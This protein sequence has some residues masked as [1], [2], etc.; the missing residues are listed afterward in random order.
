MKKLCTQGIENSGNHFSAFFKFNLLPMALFQKGVV[1]ICIVALLLFASNG[2]YSQTVVFV[3]QSGNNSNS[4]T[5]WTAAKGPTFISTLGGTNVGANYKIYVKGSGTPYVYSNANGIQTNGGFLIKGGFPS[6]ATGTDTSGYNPVAN[7]TTI[8]ITS[9]TLSNGLILDGNAVG[10][11]VGAFRIQGL[12]FNGNSIGNSGASAPRIFYGTLG[13]SSSNIQLD[14]RDDEFYNF[15]NNGYQVVA[16]QDKG[17]YSFDN[18][19][20][21]DNSGANEGAAISIQASSNATLTI[22]NCSFVN[23]TETSPS[24]GGGGAVA[25]VAPTNTITNSYF[26]SNTGASGGAIGTGGGSLISLGNWTLT[27]CT[28]SQNT[29]TTYWGGAVNLNS[30]SA[31]GSVNISSCN[32]YSNSNTSGTYGGGA[33]HLLGWY[34]STVDNCVFYNNSIASTNSAALAA[35]YG[36]GA[37]LYSG[38]QG[39]G[40][41]LTISNSVLDSNAVP[42]AS[43]GGAVEFPTQ[44]GIPAATLILNNVIFVN[45]KLGSSATTNGCDFGMSYPAGS[46]NGAYQVTNSKMQLSTSGS[47][48]TYQSP[49][50]S[51]FTFGSGNIFSNTT[52]AIAPPVLSCPTGINPVAA[53][54]SGTVWNDVDGSVTIN[55]SE[56]GT[57]G[58][59]LFVNLVDVTTGTVVGSVAVAANGTY[60]GLTYPFGGDTYKLVVSTSA[61]SLI[62]GPVPTGYINTGEN[63][64][65]NTA[66][67]SA[68]LGQIELP[69]SFATSTL[70]NQ[71]FGITLAGYIYVHK[72]AIDENSSINFTFNITGGPTSVPTIT[73]NDQPNTSVPIKDLG[74]SQNGRLW[75]VGMNNNTLYYRDLG[76]SLWVTTTITNANAVDGGAGSSVYY[77]TTGGGMAYFDGT[78][79]TQIFTGTTAV[80]VGSAWDNQPFII[81][82]G[83]RIYQYS[84]S[85]SGVV[86]SAAWPQV[87]SSANNINVDG[88]PSTGDAI[89]SKS[90]NNVWRITSAGTA[91]SLGRPSQ[92]TSSANAND[93]AVDAFGGIYSIYKSVSPIAGSGAF[94]FAWTGGTNW[95]AP[96]LSG[97]NATLASNQITAGVGGQ[98]WQATSTTGPFSLGNIF[99]RTNN[100]GTIFW[101]DNDWLLAGS[102]ITNTQ[103]IP[104][105]P[106]TYTLAETVPS[107]W[108]LTAIDIYDP[109][110]NSSGVVATKTSS[111]NVA[112]GEV[113]HVNY[114]NQLLQSL[115]I[116]TGCGTNYVQTYGSGVAANGSPLPGL[117]SYHY[118]STNKVDDGYYTIIK[119]SASWSN[120]TL[121]D[122]TGLANGYFM[123]VNASYTV[124]EFYRQRVTGLSVGSSYTLS[125]WA[126]DLS[127]TAVLRPNVTMGVAAVNTGVTINSINTGN[128]TATNWTLYSFTFIANASTVDIFIANNASGGTGNDIAIDDISFNLTP[129]PALVTTVTHSTCASATGSITVTTS[130]GANIEYS[131]D[132]FAIPANTQSSPV[133]SGITPG[134]YTIYARYVST[135]CTSSKI[136]T[137]KAA[138]CGNV[139]NDLNGLSDNTVNGIGTNAG[140]VNA[141]LYDSTG[142]K[143]VAVI[144]VPASGVIDFGGV[145]VP[146]SKYTV[147]LTT[148]TAIVGQTAVPTVTTPINW[149]NT[150]ENLGSGTGSDGTPNGVLPLG[151]VSANLNNANIGIE[152]L[153]TANAVAAISQQNPG[154][155]AKITVPTLTG[156]DPEDGSYIGTSLT[157]TIKIQSLAIGGTLYYNG[158]AVT[159]GQVIT[160]YNPALLSV[161]PNTATASVSFTYSEVDAAG[162]VSSAA[163]VTMPFTDPVAWG[164]NNAQF[165]QVKGTNSD[166]RLYTINPNTLDS[167]LITT[168]PN[169]AQALAYNPTD[170]LLWLVDSSIYIDRI[171]ANGAKLRMNIPNFNPSYGANPAKGTVTANGYYI[172]DSNNSNLGSTYYTIDI[173]PARGTY[174]QYV[175]PQNGFATI[176]TAPYARKALAAFG[177]VSDWAWN[178][179]D[180]KLYGIS[181]NGANTGFI[182]IFDYTTGIVS[183][184]PQVVRTNGI[185]LGANTYG[186][187]AFDASG[188]LTILTN[189]GNDY[190]AVN[191]TTGQAVLLSNGVATAA[192]TDGAA[193]PTAKLSQIIIGNVYNDVN[194]LTDNLVNGIA[195]NAGGGLYAVLYDNT[196]GKV[197]GLDS[198]YNNGVYSFGATPADNYSVYLTSTLPVIGQNATPPITLPTGWVSTGEGSTA[199]GDLTPNSIIVL[200]PVNSDVVNANFG[201]EQRPGAGAG[202]N[203][204][205]NPGGTNQ[206]T[207]P[208]NTFTNITSSTDTVT[209]TV[210]AI[211]IT[212]FPTGATSIVIG[213]TSFNTLAAIQA[214][215]P[216][217]IPTN[218]SGQPTPTIT[219]DPV[220]IGYGSVTIPFVA[221]DAAGMPSLNTGTAVL[222]LTAPLPPVA[223][224][225]ANAPINN[226]AAQTHIGCFVASDPQGAPIT[227]FTV[228]TL[229]LASQGVLYTCSSNNVPCTGSYTAVT[230]NQ[231]LT[232]AQAAALYFDPAATFVGTSTFTYNA[233]SQNGT[234]NTATEA[235]PVI[236][237]PPT[238]NSFTTEPVAKNSSNNPLPAL[239]GADADGTVVSYTVTPPL[240]AQGTITYCVTPPATG[241]GTPISGA[242]V[243]TSAQAAT[244][245][246]TPASNS[247]GNATFTYT[248]TDN[249]GNVSTPA[250]VT[251]PV[252]AN[253]APPANLPPVTQDVTVA[254]LNSND[255]SSLISPLIGTDPDG[256]IASYTINTIPSAAT[257]IL[258]YCTTGNYPCTGTLTA[259]TASQTLTP[260]QAQTL[261][262]DPAPGN[263]NPAVFTYSATDNSGLGSNVSTYTIP[264]VN[265][266]PTAVTIQATVPFN[267]TNAPIPSLFGTDP[268]GTIA[269]YKVTTVPNPATEG[270]LFYCSNGTVPCTGT[271]SAITSNTVLTP[272]QALTVNFTP[273]TGFVGTATGSY[274]ATDNNGNVSQPAGIILKVDNFPLTGQPPVA[275][276]SSVNIGAN[277]GSTALANTFITATDP[278]G[279]IASYKITSLPPASQG[280]YTYCT[281][282]PSSGCNTLLTV[283]LVLTPTQAAALSFTPIATYSGPAVLGFTATDNSGNV[284]NVANSVVNINSE[285]P[286]ASGYTTPVVKNGG[287]AINTLLQATDPLDNGTI[288]SF[289]ITSIPTTGNGTLTY[290]VAP[291]ATGCN[292]SIAAGTT[293]TPAQAATV[294]YTPGANMSVYEVPFT[295]TATDNSGNGSNVGTIVVPVDKPLPP[296][297]QNIMNAPMNNSLSQTHIGGFVASDPQGDPITSYLVLTLPQV[298][299]G[300]LYT[301]SSNNVP[302]TGSYT[303]VTANQSLTPAQ[304]AALYFDPANTFVGTSTFTYNATSQN[305]TSNTATETIPVINNPPTANSFTT[306]P[307]IVNSSNNLLPPL[308]GADADGTVVSYTVTPPVPAQ[309]SISYCTTPP[310]TGCGSP[311]SGTTVLTP[312]QAAT[313]SFTPATGV[314]G[315]V[316]FTYTAKDNNG[317]VSTAATVIVPITPLGTPPANLPP[318]TQDV[319]IAPLNSNDGSSLI[320]PLIAS[321]PDGTIASY[322]INTIPSASIGVLYYCT[323]GNYPCTGSLTAVTA[324]QTLTGNQYAT[325]QFD[326]ASGNNNP[327]VFTY[328]A[329]DNSSLVSNV[330]TYTIPIQNMPPTAVTIQATVPFNSTNSKI[331]VLQGT[332]PDGTIA[333]YKVTTVPNAATEGTLYYCSN[334]TIPCTG[335]LTAITANTVLMPAQAL[336]VNFTPVTGFTGTANGTYTSTDNN[337]NV[338]LP[339]GIVLRISNYMPVGQPPYATGS[340]VNI[341]ANAGSTPLASNFITATDLDGTIT[342]YKITS[343][344]PTSQGVYTY[345]SNPPA[346]GCGTPLTLGLV[347]TPAQAAVLSFTPVAT[348]SGPA[349]LGFTATDNSGNV[350]NVANSVVNISSEPP[351]AT[352]YTTAVV[353]NGGPAINT[354]L[355]ATD[356][357]DNGTI[358]SYTISSVPTSGNGTLTYCVTPPSSGCGTT[359]TTGMVLSPAQ[360]ATISYTPGTNMTAFEVP[361]TFTATDNSGNLSNVATIVIPRIDNTLCIKSRVYL[362]G[363]LMN[364]SNVTAGGRPLMRDN[365]RNSPITGANYI[366]VTDPYEYATTYVDVTSKYTKMSP[367]DAAHPQFRKVTDSTAVFSVTGQNAIIDWAFVE[368]RSKSNSA[369]VLATR[370]G[371]IQRD[372]D[373]VDVDGVSCLSFPGVTVDSYFVAIRHRS[374]LGVMTKYGQSAT[375]L[376]SLV[377]L[378]ATTTPVYDKG[379]VGANNYT[380]LATN[381]NIQSG[382]RALWQGD[383][384]A[385]KKVKYDN[386]NDDLAVMLDDVLG[387]AGNVNFTTNFDFGYGYFQ[388]DYDMNSK[389]KYDNPND[390]NSMLLDQILG[391]PLNSNFITNFDFMIQQ[392]P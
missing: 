288:A 243:L 37:I 389:V 192:N 154:G 24:Q 225:I 135:T 67:Q 111:L 305:G 66:T 299:E 195:T 270:T 346:T 114:T 351:I 358:V 157:N 300:I 124:N 295:F 220:A 52:V 341:G 177:T 173:N 310:S 223:Q 13:Q 370:A 322:T 338:S 256:T 191:V 113:V 106:G 123:A 36:G 21:H 2:A 54:L 151:I 218:A 373:I 357:L 153:P 293:L 121:T 189:T 280:A 144:A 367:Q 233:T 229:P 213:G 155:N 33:L 167:T 97:G 206:V 105:V 353:K 127:P 387:H 159:L 15:N 180:G 209:N 162:Q 70:A 388:G 16:S 32:F 245:S 86:N 8:S 290:C 359:I 7:P 278:D 324:S 129:I 334:G 331:P 82:N 371:L 376:Q 284:S 363:A 102:S 366:P 101:H 90:D 327:A 161:D 109:T 369:T 169:F 122:H 302:C 201:I 368:L 235:I 251:V 374:H 314:T 252:T 60:S 141:V 96:E 145:A 112:A 236:N 3:S 308:T 58:G 234:S 242:T 382:Y 179:A 317:N 239:T 20:F 176:N 318:I 205:I 98:A 10:N 283:G 319:T 380:G 274:T 355:L 183:L 99:S 139:Y 320:S 69:S 87:G 186:T 116:G 181:G 44:V 150:G 75:A 185:V 30:A 48:L 146:G 291:P 240:A 266:P 238:A 287:P 49:S 18:C 309:G 171:D 117:T 332:D 190:F 35:R 65:T 335:T 133:F 231:V 199:S 294:S 350:S 385:D 241:C 250:T 128:I 74:S 260:A 126:A 88:D 279:T 26:C 392:L 85:G 323:T 307:V 198:V 384:N 31:G 11:V 282:P 356:P 337:G 340:S 57:N 93:L 64:G 390:D 263:N 255:G 187:A 244:I 178:I 264:V 304:T 38:T 202:S 249:N 342:S 289:T 214:A 110:N 224:N 210:T 248:S 381:N 77:V 42:S 215:Y 212:A 194:G 360:A 257:G 137:V 296:V 247:T 152:Q 237:N 17:S 297:A 285:P 377:D 182:Q 276:G 352:G 378:T 1:R 333:T 301:C 328:S 232:P 348:Y 326:P 226:S 92:A 277:V 27:N 312:T 76:S 119:N 386:P 34:N 4:G 53:D 28:F 25:S 158:V 267:S 29:V 316:P 107:G 306:N 375:S 130:V 147:F 55:N 258:Y 14:F 43:W 193:C 361:F 91:T 80:D 269:N 5:S 261:Q 286:I 321:D 221:I 104:V 379:V 227:S 103:M 71:N 120:T 228:V 94:P 200:G 170:G 9:T 89:V 164:C 115:A 100:N 329:T 78:T 45:N 272:A 216:N 143:V 362:E 136:D 118:G 259:V 204:V 303:A 108:A 208:A 95:S 84:G 275:K 175:D 253:G 207:V 125:F 188:R 165:F 41:S 281:N 132:N 50:N 73:I 344:P 40:K 268:D 365:L 211:K 197:V 148:S 83:G 349:V 271:Q 61:T 62:P 254:P 47:Y 138:I 372:G 246:F 330:S 79:S 156:S 391:Y 345:C 298:S 196:T 354:P 142:L 39:S 315:N 219:V 131:V 313:I 172:V 19:Y 217:G 383:F 166:E 262:F 23:N 364:N 140:G 203:T 311:I 273:V 184:G 46:G 325:L 339:A 134:F 168:F 222:N 292:T 265:Q 56:T 51:P 160:N 343:L 149:V 68:T 336:T 347:L 63:V 72:K 81:A 6:T 12:R 163:T 230:P 174:L 22:N 59:G